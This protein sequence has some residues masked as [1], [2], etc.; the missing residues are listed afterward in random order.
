[1]PTYKLTCKVSTDEKGLHNYPIFV[2]ADDETEAE[3]KAKYH[4]LLDK[5]GYAFYGVL[6]SKL[7]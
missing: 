7:I 4:F 5:E 3:I 6:E 1:M 2:T